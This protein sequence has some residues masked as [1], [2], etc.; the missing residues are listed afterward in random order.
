VFV[1]NYT[2]NLLNICGGVYYGLFAARFMTHAEVCL[3][4]DHIVTNYCGLHKNA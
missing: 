2:S 4:R 3:T 1:Y